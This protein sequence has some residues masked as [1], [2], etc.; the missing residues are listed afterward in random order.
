MLKKKNVQQKTELD[1]PWLVPD[2][3]YRIKCFNC[4]KKFFCQNNV[5]MELVKSFKNL[6]KKLPQ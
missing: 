5:F 3:N 4:Q 2:G 1:L 6:S